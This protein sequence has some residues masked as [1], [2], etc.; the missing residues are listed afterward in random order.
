MSHSFAALHNTS[1]PR[2]LILG[3]KGLNVPD[4]LRILVDATVTA[5][6]SHAGNCSDAASYPLIL[7]AVSLV[8]QFLRLDVAV[9]V[10]RH[11]VVVSVVADSRNHGT[12]VVRST[13]CALLDLL[14]HGIQV[15][16]DSV[17]AVGVC[18]TKILHI[19]S[20]I[21]EQEDVVLSNFASDLDL[22]I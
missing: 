13:K 17:R 15:R 7:V 18:V 21:S 14:K 10:I 16:V 12:K 2:A 5:E 6:E 22:L 4:A 9:E 3:G 1:L 19:L 11:Q 20:E 8:N